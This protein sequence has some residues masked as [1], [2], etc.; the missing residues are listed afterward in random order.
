VTPE[1]VR[2]Q[3]HTDNLL[4]VEPIKMDQTLIANLEPPRFETSRP[5]L[6][7]GLGQR[8]SCE[9]S[10][11]IPAQWQRFQP[12]IG[13]IPGALRCHSRDARRH[14]PARVNANLVG[15]ASRAP[16]LHTPR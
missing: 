4:L 14:A 1:Q 3:R 9:S 7:V 12:C 8:Y 15:R 11:A 10:A 2:A 5:L 13:N 6:I 16:H